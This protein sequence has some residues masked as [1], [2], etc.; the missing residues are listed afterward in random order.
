M[1]MSSL[2][3]RVRWARSVAG[4]SQEKLAKLEQDA[5]HLLPQVH[6][7][8]RPGVLIAPSALAKCFKLTYCGSSTLA[9]TAPL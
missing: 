8:P 5:R 7:T 9:V 3:E 6:K 2:A 4:V 1:A